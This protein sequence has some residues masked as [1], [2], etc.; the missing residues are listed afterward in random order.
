MTIAG[1]NVWREGAVG[2]R[3]VF[4]R[5]KQDELKNWNL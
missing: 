4:R 1:N 5:L 3:M 2:E